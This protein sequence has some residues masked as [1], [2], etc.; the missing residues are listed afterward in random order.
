MRKLM[1]FL[2]FGVFFAAF[3]S[4]LYAEPNMAEIKSKQILVPDTWGYEQGGAFGA[5]IS[6]DGKTLAFSSAKDIW[7][8]HTSDGKSMDLSGAWKLTDGIVSWYIN[9][10]RDLDWSYDGIIELIS[11]S[12]CRINI[13]CPVSHQEYR[14]SSPYPV[15]TFTCGS[16]YL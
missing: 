8:M 14:F 13:R 3:T 4:F 15:R 6:P 10:G 7:I 2:V 11:G 12:A 9:H 1:A 5:D 16:G